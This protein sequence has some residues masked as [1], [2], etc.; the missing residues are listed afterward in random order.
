MMMLVGVTVPVR[1]GSPGPT[2]AGAV[3]VAGPTAV[4]P[5]TGRGCARKR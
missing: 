4:S 5:G 1:T 2:P 3:V